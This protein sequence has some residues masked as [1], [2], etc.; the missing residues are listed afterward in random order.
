MCPR[1]LLPVMVQMNSIME[2]VSECA[3]SG[4]EELPEIVF[5]NVRCLDP[6]LAD[7]GIGGVVYRIR[8]EKMA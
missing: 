2:M 1:A 5:R 7:G 4:K 6:G 3:H 8:T